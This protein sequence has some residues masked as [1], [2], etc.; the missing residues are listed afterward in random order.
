MLPFDYTDDGRIFAVHEPFDALRDSGRPIP[1]AVTAL[2]GITD[3]MV[4]GASIDPAEVASFLRPAAVSQ[5]PRVTP[6]SLGVINSLEC[7]SASG[8]HAD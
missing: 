6:P 8:P 1:A 4:A 2:T 7:R 5:T 3:A